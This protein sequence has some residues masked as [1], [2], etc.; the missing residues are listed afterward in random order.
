MS[1]RQVELLESIAMATGGTYINSNKPVRA[2]VATEDLRK[3]DVDLRIRER[4]SN[5]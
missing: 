2:F 3:S 1:M 5:L 4:N